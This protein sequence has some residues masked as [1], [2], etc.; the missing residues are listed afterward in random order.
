MGVVRFLYLVRRFVVAHIVEPEFIVCNERVVF[1]VNGAFEASKTSQ[2]FKRQVKPFLRLLRRNLPS[3]T[4]LA[5]LCAYNAF[6]GC[7][8]L[9]RWRKRRY[10]R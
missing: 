2:Q 9:S 5:F 7:N 1:V 3:R 10:S 8:T 4:F 6:C